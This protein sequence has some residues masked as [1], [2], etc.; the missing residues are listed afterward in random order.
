MPFPTTRCVCVTEM[1]HASMPLG[2]GW[3]VVGSN[4]QHPVWMKPSNA[5]HRACILHAQLARQHPLMR[6]PAHV[7]MCE[8]VCCLCQVCMNDKNF[9]AFKTLIVY[10]SVDPTL[11]VGSATLFRTPD[12][13]LHVT[14]QMDCPYFIWCV[15]ADGSCVEAGRRGRGLEAWSLASM[16]T[17]WHVACA[18]PEWHLG[19]CTVVRG[20][21]LCTGSWDK[22]SVAHACMLTRAHVLIVSRR[23]SAGDVNMQDNN[24]V[25]LLSY[26]D[27]TNPTTG[28]LQYTRV[29]LVRVQLA[30]GL[31]TA[32]RTRGLHVADTL[33]RSLALR[34]YLAAAFYVQCAQL[35]IQSDT[36]HRPPPHA[37]AARCVHPI[38][39][40]TRKYATGDETY[41]CYT[42]STDI[43]FLAPSGQ[44]AGCYAIDIDAKVRGAHANTFKHL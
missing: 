4:G 6:N 8:S 28:D 38:R 3:W 32:A 19:V 35:S 2:G 14:V 25:V 21:H 44:Q 29:P 30:A 41:A 15:N 43:N 34:A 36:P 26:P 42:F 27:P 16:N 39:P 40:Q 17:P 10:S 7:Y 22:G 13:T 23:S 5:A 1:Q 9:V 18:G 31:P 24:N 33:A 11:I 12:G 20:G 37:A